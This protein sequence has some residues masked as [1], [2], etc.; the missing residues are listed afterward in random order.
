MR[1]RTLQALA[2]ALTLS[3]L[4][5]HAET[6]VTVP[7]GQLVQYDRVLI[8]LIDQS[9]YELGIDGQSSIHGYVLGNGHTMVDVIG[10]GTFYYTFDRA[11]IL[12]IQFLESD[13]QSII[14]DIHEVADDHSFVVRYQDGQL[15]AA[16][17]AV[18]STCRIYTVAGNPV[19]SFVISQ[20]GNVDLPEL[21]P[22]IYLLKA[23]GITFKIMK[24]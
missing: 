21:T 7:D 1:Y 12:S 4:P 10:T 19:S 8:T 17:S 15:Q 2:A 6:T 22:G 3:A 23:G 14:E 9:Q 24:Q 16:P 5:L 18:G 20:A 11:E 13:F